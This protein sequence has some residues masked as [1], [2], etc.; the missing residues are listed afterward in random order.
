MQE[1]GTSLYFSFLNTEENWPKFSQIMKELY[2]T[3]LELGG[4]ISGANCIGLV[5]A[6]FIRDELGPALDV[7]KLIKKSLDPENI[8]NPGKMGV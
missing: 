8:M 6:P 3:V 4:S 7:M 5:N 2:R 1:F